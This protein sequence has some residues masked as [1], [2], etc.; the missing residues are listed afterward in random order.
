M[1]VFLQWTLFPTDVLSMSAFF[2]FY[3]FSSTFRRF[4]PVDVFYILC[5]FQSTFFYFETFCSS[6]R[7]L[8]TFL[9]ST[10]CPSR[11]LFHSTFCP[12]RR[13]FL[14]TFCRWIF[15][16]RRP[17]TKPPPVHGLHLPRGSGSAR[18]L[19][20]V[21]GGPGQVADVSM[22]QHMSLCNWIVWPGQNGP[23]A[24]EK[25]LLHNCLE[26]ET[27]QDTFTWCEHEHLTWKVYFKKTIVI[28]GQV[29]LVRLQTD[30]ICLFLCQ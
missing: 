29:P 18:H 22:L 13:F 30:N 16:T 26:Y 25:L 20:V 7:F 21:A 1:S 12:I 10:F 27:L 24:P 8:S 9:S 5:F 4:V 17:G 19:S 23:L 11:R 3:V 28:D 15:I 6:R 2:T 14:S